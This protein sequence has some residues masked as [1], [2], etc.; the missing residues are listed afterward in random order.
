MKF[1]VL[2]FISLTVLHIQLKFDTWIRQKN[3]HV[4]FEFGYG[5]MM[6]GRV[7]IFSLKKKEEMFC[8]CSFF[9]QT[10]LHIRLKLNI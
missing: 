5:L 4:K 8:F 3:A 1:S 2:F 10:V 7:M 9:A 6:F